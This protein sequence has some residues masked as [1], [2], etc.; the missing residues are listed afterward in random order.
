LVGGAD[1]ARDAFPSKLPLTPTMRRVRV[2]K[3]KS[4]KIA[5]TINH[6]NKW[7]PRGGE[8]EM[9][10]TRTH[11]TFRVDTWTPD[12]ESIVEHVAGL[13]SITRAPCRKVI[14]VPGQRW[15]AARTAG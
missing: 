2:R 1:A 8:G 15:Q 9:A 5:S 4:R 6:A 12:G 10:V 14:G 7:L 11:F 13:S 3:S